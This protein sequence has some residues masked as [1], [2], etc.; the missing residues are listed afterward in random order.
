[1]TTPGKHIAFERSILGAPRRVGPRPH[2]EQ[3]GR[4]QRLRD[5]D[6][7]HRDGARRERRRGEGQHGEREG[8]G[9]HAAAALLAEP[10]AVD[11]PVDHRDPAGERREREDRRRERGAAQRVGEAPADDACRER[12]RRGGHEPEVERAAQ[13]ELLA[14]HERRL[15]HQHRK[16]RA[17][18]ARR[19]RGHHL[20]H[21]GELR[22]ERDQ[23]GAAAQGEHL[24]ER[25][26]PGEP[27]RDDGER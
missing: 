18:A 19:H 25:R 24:V 22:P 6:R 12:D 1:M 21:R 7:L 2:E 4:R 13:E 23:L 26:A 14:F 15:R 5:H 27:E 11:Q 9:E 20:D 3:H 10:E 17:H 16:P 8:E